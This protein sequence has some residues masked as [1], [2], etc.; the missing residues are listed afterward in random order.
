MNNEVCQKFVDQYRRNTYIYPN[1]I[2]RNC[3]G[4]ITEIC[5]Y[6]EARD[7]LQKAYVV[8]CPCCSHASY[9]DSLND[10]P[11]EFNCPHC[12][13]ESIIPINSSF[14]RAI[15]KKIGNRREKND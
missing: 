10:I 12:D 13:N 3:G 8:L 11:Q 5:N 14:I 2:K 4:T 7:D 1:V 9:Y 6:L 15:Y